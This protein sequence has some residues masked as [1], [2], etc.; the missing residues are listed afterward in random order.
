MM[1][2]DLPPA[3][4][5]LFARA[6]KTVA[7]A[8]GELHDKE[9]EMIALALAHDGTPTPDALPTITPAALARGIEAPALRRAIVQRL[10]VLTTLDGRVTGDE[11][12]AVERF[13][14]ALGVRERAVHNARQLAR[15]HARRVMLDLAPRS[16]MPAVLAHVWRTDGVRGLWKILKS[17]LG[18][19]DAAQAARFAALGELPQ[20]TL[21]RALHEHFVR[22]ELTPPGAPR[23]VPDHM[24]MHDLGHVLAGYGTRPEDELCVASFQ[25]GFLGEGWLVMYLMIAMLFQLAIEPVARLRGVEPRRGLVDV[26][27]LQRAFELGAGM[28]RSLVGWDPWPHMA[29]PL[30]EVRA[31]LGVAV[32]PGPP[33]SRGPTSVRSTGPA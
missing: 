33:G 24:L 21:G 18:F 29:R 10:V 23:G 12:T 30:V 11:V 8:D 19:A 31:E 5:L 27:G 25:A 9:R 26:R 4:S 14:A 6:L 3:A 28:K 32:S 7:L 15:G 13:A 22:G 2:L 16:F 20:G 17:A 1:Q